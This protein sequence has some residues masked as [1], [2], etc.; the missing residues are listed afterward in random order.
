[1]EHPNN[2]H[3]GDEHF[4]NCSEVVPC[5][6]V[7]MYGQYTVEPLNNGHVGDILSIVQRLSL[8]PRY[9]C[10]DNNIQVGGKQFVHCREVV[11]SWE[12]PLSEVRENVSILVTLCYHIPCKIWSFPLM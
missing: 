3:V 2:G 9:K 4:V 1:M 12:C 10:M 8:F 5:S 11:N 7:E 6:E